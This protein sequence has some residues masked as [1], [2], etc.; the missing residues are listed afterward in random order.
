MVDGLSLGDVLG[1]RGSLKDSF[2]RAGGRFV[3]LKRDGDIF[4]D[5]IVFVGDALLGVGLLGLAVSGI[6]IR[7]V[8]DLIFI[9]LGSQ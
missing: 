2:W 8:G 3:L 9:S 5:G 7:K 6:V 1:E 4:V